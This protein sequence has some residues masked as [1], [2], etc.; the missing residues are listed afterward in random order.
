MV[1]P[2]LCSGTGAD[3][4]CPNKHLEG[5]VDVPAHQLERAMAPSGAM[6]RTFVKVGRPQPEE[7]YVHETI[8]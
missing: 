4:V 6:T 2:L 8:S 1:Q 7:L 3:S 5:F